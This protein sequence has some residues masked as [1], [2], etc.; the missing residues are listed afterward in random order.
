MP[1]HDNT[2]T[3]RSLVGLHPTAEASAEWS[4]ETHVRPQ[5]PTQSDE[6]PA[7]YRKHISLLERPESGA[8]SL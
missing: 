6:R 4:V 7:S 8:L 2:S 5:Y 1:P 3:R